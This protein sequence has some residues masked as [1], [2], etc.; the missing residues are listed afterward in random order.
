[1]HAL[2]DL[3]STDDGL[4]RVGGIVFMLGM[5]VFFVRYMARHIREDGERAAHE[6]AKPR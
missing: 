1:M 4:M 2:Q 6:A 5:A 3:F